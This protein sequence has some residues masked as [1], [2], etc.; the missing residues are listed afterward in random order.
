[1][2]T[3]VCDR[4][5]FL[6]GASPATPDLCRRCRVPSG[7]LLAIALVPLL[8]QGPAIAQSAGFQPGVD[9]PGLDFRDFDLRG[10]ATS[11]QE[12]C[13]RDRRCRAWTW[14]KAGVQGSTPRC[15]LKTAAPPAVRNACCTSGIVTKFDD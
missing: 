3:I 9:R 13:R 15:W 11:C 1:M 10:D 2:K 8:W 14:V 12:T 6:V 5:R 4:A 7:L